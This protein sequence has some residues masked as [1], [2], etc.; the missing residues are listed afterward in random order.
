MEKDECMRR[1]GR[2]GAAALAVRIQRLGACS[3][4]TRREI[5]RIPIREMGGCP[6]DGWRWV[7]VEGVESSES[8]LEPPLLVLSPRPLRCSR[9][10]HPPLLVYC[11]SR[12]L[13]RCLTC[14]LSRK[15]RSCIV[16]ALTLHDPHDP[17]PRQLKPTHDTFARW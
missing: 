3:G 16:P 17:H 12:Y 8:G 15:T 2:L 6:W 1:R 7:A 10:F 14:A 11:S 13:L 4:S 5:C 9:P